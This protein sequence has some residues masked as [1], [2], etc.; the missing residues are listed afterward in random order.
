MIGEF[1][2]QTRDGE[3]VRDAVH[4]GWIWRC[5]CG[6]EAMCSE[7]VGGHRSHHRELGEK[8]PKRPMDLVPSPDAPDPETCGCCGAPREL[9]RGRMVGV[10]TLGMLPK[11]QNE[12]EGLLFAA[13]TRKR[14]GMAHVVRDETRKIYAAIETAAE[15]LDDPARGQ[16][17]VEIEFVKG[18]R[19]T[20][21]DDPGNRA[22]RTKAV[23]DGL[24]HAGLLIDD[25]DRNL[26]LPMP[27]ES[28]AA[29][30]PQTIVTIHETERHT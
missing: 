21:R 11:S 19:S 6:F 3:S 13:V 5:W 20:S 1:R 2:P 30:G 9:R 15:Q 23:L 28:K 27:R 29:A 8:A 7:D 16:R 4:G 24:V 18:P 14:P 26:V 17:I 10:I 25:D 12:R 22:V